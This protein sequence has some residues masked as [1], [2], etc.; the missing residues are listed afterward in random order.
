MPIVDS[1]LR[2]II[3]YGPNFAPW[4]PVL[5]AVCEKYEINTP[6]RLAHFIAQCAHESGSFMFTIENL[7]YSADQLCKTWPTLFSMEKAMK[8]QR[9]PE[10]IANYVY[11]NR[12]GN[13]DELSGD[14]WRYRGKGL[15]QLTGKTNQYACADGVGI[16]RQ[17][18]HEWLESIPGACA[19]AGWYWDLHGLNALADRD[20]VE[21]VT[22]VINGGFIGLQDRKTLTKK[23]KEV[24]KA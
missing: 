9:N 15:L 23:A 11:A 6:L 1:D 13:G 12:M 21:Q 22:R 18:V 17:V 5:T 16:D 24:F 20:D 14:G 8:Y 3:P 2:A 19:S 10:M 4:S 7:N